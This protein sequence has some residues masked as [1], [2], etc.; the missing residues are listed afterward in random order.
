M[1]RILLFAFAVCFLSCNHNTEPT[2]SK[3]KPVSEHMAPA[4]IVMTYRLK[5][6]EL[7]GMR[8]SVPLFPRMYRVEGRSILW[9]VDGDNVSPTIRFECVPPYLTNNDRTLL[10]SGT[11]KFA[12]YDD[13]D[14]GGGGVR[15]TVFLT[16]CS[17][18]VR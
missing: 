15:F 16:N 14:R 17:V 10:V 4:D 6:R 13:E 7:S 3:F 11:V 8:I 2:D 1:V 5:A 18:Q 12:I 9:Y